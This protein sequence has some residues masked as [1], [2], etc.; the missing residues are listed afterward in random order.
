MSLSDLFIEVSE[1][2]QD[3]YGFFQ[4][5]FLFCVYGYILMV[6]SDMISDG[7]E[8]LLLIPACTVAMHYILFVI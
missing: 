2:P 6:A 8:F 7:S 5:M 4:I 3:F 1:L